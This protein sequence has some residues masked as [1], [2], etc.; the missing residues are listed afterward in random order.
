MIDVIIFLI[1]GLLVIVSP[2]PLF[3]KKKTDDDILCIVDISNDKPFRDI[4]KCIDK[5]FR[6]IDKYKDK[7]IRQMQ[8]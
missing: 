6:E 4:D 1:A 7:Y 5:Y 3:P 8:R 2:H